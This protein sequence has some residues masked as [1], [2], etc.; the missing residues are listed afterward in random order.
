MDTQQK[1]SDIELETI[2]EE[3]AIYMCACPGQVA[4]EIRSLR[5]LIR[6]QQDCIKSDQAQGTVHQIIA[7]ASCDA[8]ALM[9]SCLERVLETEGWDRET[10]KMPDGLRQLRTELLRDV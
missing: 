6:Y 4:S 3:A 7:A 2:I 10:L 9:E 1:F 5:N 8:H